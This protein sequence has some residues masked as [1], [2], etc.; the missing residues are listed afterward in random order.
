VPLQM[1]ILFFPLTYFLFLIFFCLLACL[2]FFVYWQHL[3]IWYVYTEVSIQP[4][5][6]LLVNAVRVTNWNLLWN[7]CGKTFDPARKTCFFFSM[8]GICL[9]KCVVVNVTAC[10]HESEMCHSTTLVPTF[11]D[12]EGCSFWIGTQLASV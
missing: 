12:F 1:L 3:Y 8:T 6:F 10:R 7:L 2:I 11:V 4:Q 9:Q 5:S